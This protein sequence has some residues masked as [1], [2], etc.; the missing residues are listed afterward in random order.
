MVKC[1]MM[2]RPQF[3]SK[4][5]VYSWQWKS[6]RIG[7][8]CDEHGYSYEWINGQ[9]NHISKQMVF[10]YCAIRKTSYQSWFL[11]YQRLLPQACLLQYPWHIQGRTLIILN[12]PQARLPHQPWHLQGRLI[13]QITLQQSCQAKVWIDKYGRTRVG[14]ITIP[15]SCQVKV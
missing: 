10:E 8:R 2:K 9:K 15:L 1:R 14:R 12:L 6:S 11:V 13:I 7:K 3:M 5:W 4:N